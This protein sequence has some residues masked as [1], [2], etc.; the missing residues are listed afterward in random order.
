M[1]L[2]L[3]GNKFSPK[4]TPPRRAQSLSNLDAAEAKNEFAIDYGAVKVSLGG[5][6]V[7]FENGIWVNG[8]LFDCLS[9]LRFLQKVFI[10]FKCY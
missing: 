5:N 8:K 6:D 9:L 1:P 4:K 3:F 10:Y 7:A 2:G